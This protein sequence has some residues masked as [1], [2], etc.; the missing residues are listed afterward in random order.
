GDATLWGPPGTP[1]VANRLGWLTIAQRMLDELLEIERVADGVRQDGI[2]DAVLLGMG[3]SSLA[4]EVFRRA[5][6]GPA[7][8]PGALRLHVLDSTDPAWIASV[9][10]AVDPARTLFIVSS[11]SGGTI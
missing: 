4:P 5:F 1:E 2:T 9:G 11:K 8:V 7:D 6:A 10:A 3:G